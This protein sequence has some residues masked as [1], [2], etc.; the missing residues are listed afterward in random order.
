GFTTIPTPTDLDYLVAHTPAPTASIAPALLKARG[1]FDEAGRQ[2]VGVTDA[3]LEKAWDWRG[4]G[5][6]RYGLFRAIESVEEATADIEA[7]L[8]ATGS[9]RSKAGLRVAPTT[10]ARWDLHGRLAALD[11]A[12]LDKVAKDGEWTIRETL[13]HI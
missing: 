5:D 1:L 12:V 3:G 7:I 2:L 9:R 13:G 11:D 4:D 8:E 6:V 10:A